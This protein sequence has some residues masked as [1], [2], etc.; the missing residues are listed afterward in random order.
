ML[1][2]VINALACRPMEKRKVYT[3]V[4][5]ASRS[6]PWPSRSSGAVPSGTSRR[7]GASSSPEGRNPFFTTDS[8]AA[9]RA[10]E[11]RADAILKATRVDASSR[12]TRRRTR[13]RSS[14]RTSLPGGPREAARRDGRR[15]D[16]SLPRQPDADPVFTCSFTEHPPRRARRAVGSVVDSGLPPPEAGNST[17][18]LR[19]MPLTEI[20]KK[21]TAHARV[22]GGLPH[23]LKHLRTGRA[24]IAFSTGFSSST[25]ARPRR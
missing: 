19:S 5:T 25:T 15:V 24:S 4:M 3:R 18:R 14:C 12:P 17:R 20:K 13:R 6:A 16:R 11:I 22:A 2:T 1:A 8:A 23:E 7:S 21:P 9:L 10:N